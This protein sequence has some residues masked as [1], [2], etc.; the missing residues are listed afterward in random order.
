MASHH[1]WNKI[2]SP[3][4][5]RWVLHRLA[6]TFLSGLI[7]S[8]FSSNLILLQAVGFVSSHRLSLTS[9]SCR[10][11]SPLLQMLFPGSWGHGS[12]LSFM[13]QFSCHLLNKLFPKRSVSNGPH[14]HTA[15]ATVSWSPMHL[16]P[17]ETL[18]FTFSF[19]MLVSPTR[20]QD[21]REP[22]PCLAYRFW[23]S[24]WNKI[25]IYPLGGQM[26]SQTELPHEIIHEF[27]FH[28]GGWIKS[29]PLSRKLLALNR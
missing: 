16:S 19:L 8:P 7:S 25:G 5:G 24:V 11:S 23:N 9:K 22:G 18:L 15:P 1:P 3:H 21:P 2:Q 10:G 12:F 14:N 6:P 20:T 27:S 29:Q 26:R 4:Y 28:R 13:S 17:P